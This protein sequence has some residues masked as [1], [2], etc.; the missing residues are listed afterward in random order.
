MKIVY[1]HI[2]TSR[3]GRCRTS[4]RWAQTPRASIQQQSPATSGLFG[5]WTIS[6]YSPR[7]SW[8]RSKT[9]WGLPPSWGLH[10]GDCSLGS[11]GWGS[12][13]GSS[14]RLSSRCIRHRI[15]PCWSKSPPW[16]LPWHLNLIRLWVCLFLR[17]C[18]TSP[19]HIAVSCE[20]RSPM[21]QS[22]L[23]SLVHFTN[24]FKFLLIC[25]P[26]YLFIA[27]FIWTQFRVFYMKV[28]IFQIIL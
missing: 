17:V 18:S 24:F 19:Q 6:D 21:N 14:Q 4:G 28:L 5:A 1:T 20:E 13:E 2:T 16:L 12:S 22:L 27:W 15:I 26:K 9:S 3:S 7:C 8:H 25:Q 23:I 11:P 10:S